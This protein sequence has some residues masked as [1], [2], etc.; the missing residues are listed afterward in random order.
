[1]S[2]MPLERCA[3]IRPLPNS[4]PDPKPKFKLGHR[5]IQIRPPRVELGQYQNGRPP[6]RQRGPSARWPGS[7][8]I[9]G[10]VPPWREMSLSARERLP[11]AVRFD[12][13]RAVVR[14]VLVPP[15]IGCAVHA[16]RGC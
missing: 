3:R 9:S 5:K 4:T 8:P 1:V 15:R 7:G 14:D 11:A 13:A 10:T 2:A 16:I 12:Q 6:R